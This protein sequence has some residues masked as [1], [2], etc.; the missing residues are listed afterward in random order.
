[1]GTIRR[2]S[3]IKWLRG[4]PAG[5]NN[6]APDAALPT[7]EFGI[8]VAARDA[9]NVDF[10]KEGKWRRRQGHGLTIPLPDAHSVFAHPEFP[11]LMARDSN[12]L[13]AMGP[14]LEPEA[15]VTGLGEDATSYCVLNGELLWTIEKRATGRIDT[16]L[17]NRPLGLPNPPGVPGLAA[18]TNG[19]LHP[20]NYRVCL[21]YL[22]AEGEESGT[23]PP[24]PTIAIDANGAITVTLLP[25]PAG[26]VATRVY[27]TEANGR[28]FYHA[29]DADP[30]ET[31]VRLI[32]GERGDEA[33]TPHLIPLPA[34]H[35]LREINGIVLMA[36]DNRVHYGEAMRPRLHRPAHNFIP[37]AARVDMLQPVGEAESAGMYVAAGKR[38]YFL[39]GATPKQA[40]IRMVRTY[41]AVPGSG[42]SVPAEV[43][44]LEGIPGEVAYWMGSD[45]TPC[46]GLP[47]GTVKVLAKGAAMTQ[48]ERGASLLREVNS[49]TQFVTAGPQG[50]VG[51]IAATDVAEVFQYRNGILIP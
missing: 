33:R 23:C 30:D 31:S 14:E 50:P 37:F 49:I 6:I 9:L 15:V 2:E 44:A 17:V 3:E 48:F 11:Y 29:F 38:V 42:L 22:D 24:S 39:A 19:G 41:G 36:V 32:E 12:T 43:A 4:L 10:T 35:I 13:Y 1:M 34:G 25:P 51:A 46:L 16:L 20:G 45:G 27:V 7:N 18:G 40:N 21:S 28:D 26:I 47:N 8:P 5:M